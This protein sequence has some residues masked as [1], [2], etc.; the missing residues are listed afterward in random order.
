MRTREIILWFR[1]VPQS[2]AHAAVW[3]ST[4]FYRLIL[5]GS[6]NLSVK[7]ERGCGL[8]LSHLCCYCYVRGTTVS[9]ATTDT[10]TGTLASHAGVGTSHSTLPIRET[11]VRVSSRSSR[12]QILDIF[13]IPRFQDFTN[14]RFQDCK[15]STFSNC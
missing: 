4:S 10:A 6:S 8:F 9:A 14:S 1:M 3:F 13:K 15:I 11:L 2:G 7:A 12:F 5:T